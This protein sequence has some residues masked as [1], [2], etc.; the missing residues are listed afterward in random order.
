MQPIAPCCTFAS[1]ERATD[2]R[3]RCNQNANPKS[4]VFL[5]T[6]IVV[7]KGGAR[8]SLQ[9]DDAPAHGDCDRF[10]AIARAKLFHDVFDVNLD[11]LFRDE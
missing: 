2:E 5:C 1:F 11:G 8:V 4:M 6:T 3:N 9:L 10:G 7:E